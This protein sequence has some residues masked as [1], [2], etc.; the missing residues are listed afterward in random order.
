M[1]VG[2]IT[3]RYVYRKN[4]MSKLKWNDQGET[5]TGVFIR[6]VYN[7][8]HVDIYFIYFTCILR[9]ADDDTV[10]SNDECNDCINNRR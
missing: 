8:I 6:L 2:L 3:N 5:V 7:D 4:S 10:C 9:D 1:A